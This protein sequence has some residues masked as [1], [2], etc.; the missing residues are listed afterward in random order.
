MTLDGVMLLTRTVSSEATFSD[1]ECQALYDRC[2]AVRK[3][4][5][6]VEIGC[7]LG[8]TS[9]IV[10]Q[11]AKERGYQ[12]IH[13]DPYTQQPEYLVGWIRMMHGI[14]HPFTFL[15]MRTEQAEDYLAKLCG[16]EIDLLLIDGDHNQP[17]VWTDCLVAGDRVVSGG[18]ML[19][20][21]F[22]RPNLPDVE[23]ALTAYIRQGDY[24]DWT[25]QQVVDSLGVWRRT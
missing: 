24:E 5:I 21:D 16:F 23:K 18:Y 15:C 7:Q 1:A 8:R 13:I 10:L 9:S 19:A 11:V 2:M 22:R 14:G 6:V 20:H 4:G 25:P 12:S 3:G 17:G